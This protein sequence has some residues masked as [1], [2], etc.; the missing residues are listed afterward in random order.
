MNRVVFEQVLVLRFS[1]GTDLQTFGPRFK[2]QAN[3]KN[4]TDEQLTGWEG[5]RPTVG[6]VEHTLQFKKEPSEAGEEDR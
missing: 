6:Q 3:N 2:G 1:W 5:N 4:D